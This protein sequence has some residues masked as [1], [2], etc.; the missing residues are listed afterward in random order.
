MI[1]MEDEDDTEWI[2]EERKAIQA[3]NWATVERYFRE[4]CADSG[5]DP[6]PVLAEA[7]SRLGGQPLLDIH[8]EETVRLIDNIRFQWLPQ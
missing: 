3:A 2:R 4:E 8:C 7:W 1:D 6:E 5:V